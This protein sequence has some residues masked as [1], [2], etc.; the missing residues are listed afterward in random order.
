MPLGGTVVGISNRTSGL[1]EITDK[2]IANSIKS[3]TST[4]TEFSSLLSKVKESKVLSTVGNISGWINTGLN[5][6]DV[7]AVVADKEYIT[8][9][10]VG[11]I[12]GDYMSSST[13][14]GVEQKYSYAKYRIKQ[15]IEE[16][17]L[18]Y[19]V[20]LFGKGNVTDYKLDKEI[21]EQLALEFMLIDSVRVNT[22]QESLERYLYNY[23]GVFDSQIVSGLI[24]DEILN[25]WEQKEEY[26]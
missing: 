8:D 7:G 14:E 25:D 16:G 6:W 15:L 24:D 23:A 9:Q 21:Q 2:S 18:T 5:T 20:S 3:I 4:V 17:K 11:K 1:T 12:V 10:L 26:E 19:D 13:K 22:G